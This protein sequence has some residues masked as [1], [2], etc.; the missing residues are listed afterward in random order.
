MLGRAMP[1]LPA[2]DM[3]RA[4]AFYTG[5]LG[6]SVMFE[7][8]SG[9]A[10]QAPDG[11]GVFVYPHERTLATHTAAAFVVD[12]V[13]A[14][15]RELRGRGVTFEDYDLPG[16]KTVDGIAELEGVKSAWLVDSEGN[17]I[18]INQMAS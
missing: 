18:A 1:V 12:D 8:E 2:E 9:A 15:V 6:L 13:T 3:A 7:S 11:T 10:F 17:I 16:L 5:K 14:V 4:K